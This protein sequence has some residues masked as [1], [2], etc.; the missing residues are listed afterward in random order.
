MAPK[1][2]MSS[3]KSD[4]AKAFV[5]FRVTGDDLVPAELSALLEVRPTHAH[6]K[7]EA[8]STGRST[9]RP[10]SGLWMF[11]TDQLLLSDIL[12]DH[13]KLAFM[14]LGLPG[15]RDSGRGI[16]ADGAVK[17]LKLADF[18][19]TRGYRATMTFFWHGAAQ[20]RRPELPEELV[21][22]FDLIPI[23]V[24]TDFD[25]DETTEARRTRAA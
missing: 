25:R 5:T 11:S 6:R 7:D 19:R 16:T 4:A 8:Y 12:D 10:S 21:R 14:V 22:L 24:E 17:L 3:M 23:A 18:L 20:S 2:A 13:I 1:S 9:V 15:G